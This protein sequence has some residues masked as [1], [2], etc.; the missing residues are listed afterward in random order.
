MAFLKLE[1]GVVRI[2]GF[3][4]AGILKLELGVVRIDGL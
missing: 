2:D 4:E 3:F 1:L